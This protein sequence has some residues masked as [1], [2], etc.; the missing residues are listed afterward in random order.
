MADDGWTAVEAQFQNG[1]DREVR[2][3]KSAWAFF[4]AAEHQRMKEGDPDS[5]SAPLPDVHRLIAERWRNLSPADKNIYEEQAKADRD[6]FDAE[7]AAADAAALEAQARRRAEREN[8]TVSGSR[9]RTQAAAKEAPKLSIRK[10]R[11]LTT[12]Q[13]A[14]RQAVR[15]ARNARDAHIEKGK[16]ENKAFLQEQASQRLQYLL[17]QSDIFQHFGRGAERKSPPRAEKAKAEASEPMSPSR[18]RAAA[19][20]DD[21]ESSDNRDDT[22]LLRQPRNLQGQLRP[23]QL[24]GLNWLIR[25]QENGVNGILA[26]EMGLGKTLQSISILAYMLEYRKIRGPHLI[27][28]PKSTLSNWMNEFRKF[29]PS[30]RPVRFHGSKEERRDLAENVIKPGAPVS[31]LSWDVLVTTYEIANIE[32]NVIS[33]FAWQYLIIDEAHRLKNEASTFSRTVRGFSMRYRLLITGTPLQNNLH[34]LWALLNFLLP[35]VFASADQFDEWFD[36]DVDD[37]EAKERMIKQLHKLLR[38]FMLRRLK[39]DVEKTLPPKSE[40]I[41]FTGMSAVQKDLYK[42]ILRRDVDAILEANKTGKTQLMNIVMQLRKVCNHPYLFPGVENRSLDPLGEHLVTNCGKMVLLDKL[43]TALKARG[44]RVLIFTQMTRQLDILEDLMNMRAYSYCRID[45]NTNYEDREDQID[46]FNAAGSGIFAFILSTRAGGLG[47]NLQTAD[48]CILYDSDWNPQMDLQAQDRCHRIGQKRP[49]SVYRLVTEHSIEEK[50]VERAQQKLKLDAMV[51][52]QGRLQDGK[53]DKMSKEELLDAVR[54][55]ADKVFRSDDSTITDDDIDAILEAGRKRTED[56]NAKL[57][58]AEKGNLFDFRL[59]GNMKTQEFEGVDY[60][61]AERSRNA[62]MET[63]QGEKMVLGLGL[64]LHKRERKPVVTN[65]AEVMHVTRKSVKRI[66]KVLK[67]PKM[68]VYQF[69]NRERI[70]ELNEIAKRRYKELQQLGEISEKSSDGVLSLLEPELEAEKAQLLGSFFNWSREL[71]QAFV[72]ASGTFGRDNL[73]K[74]AASLGL[75]VEDV[76]KYK[77]TFWSRGPQDFDATEWERI[78]KKIEQGEKKLDKV[79]ALVTGTEQFVDQ[80]EN[81]WWEVPVAMMLRNRSRGRPLSDLQYNVFEDTL[82]LCLTRRYSYGNWDKVAEAIKRAPAVMSWVSMDYHLQ[83]MSVDDIARRCEILMQRAEKDM[84]SA[85]GDVENGS[86]KASFDKKM[87]D[88]DSEYKKKRGALVARQ[89]A[90]AEELAKL[91]SALQKVRDQAPGGVKELRMLANG[92]G[93]APISKGSKSGTKR[94]SEEAGGKK[95]EERESKARRKSGSAT[96]AEVKRE[97]I[98]LLLRIVSEAGST[99]VALITDA[100]RLRAEASARQ[101]MKMVSEI[102]EKKPADGRRG[103]FWRIRPEF[104]SL[105]NDTYPEGLGRELLAQARKM[106]REAEPKANGAAKAAKADKKQPSK[107]GQQKA[108]DPARN[109]KK[110]SKADGSASGKKRARSED[111]SEDGVR[112]PRPPRKAIQLFAQ[113]KKREL[114]STLQTD[115]IE[116]LAQAVR[117]AWNALA[118]SEKLL[119]IDRE[120]EDSLRYEAELKMQEAA[121]AK[122]KK[123]SSPPQLKDAGSPRALKPKP[124][125]AAAPPSPRMPHQMPFPMVHGR[126]DGFVHQG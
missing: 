68:P 48:T 43:L 50:I 49:V 25:L 62:E 98:P 2:P 106:V 87:E 60:S 8:L 37:E 56:M 44:H 93:I 121:R 79:N 108:K 67:L 59:D 107:D 116:V 19:Q 100:F 74:I 3:A 18:R 63:L 65:M 6:R 24:E 95:G 99:G 89:D 45:G 36:L 66:P 105:L 23:Y 119:W 75:E 125:A 109:A 39:V 21:S 57:K 112:D 102:A 118:D 82:L 64:G 40:T 14:K 16:E 124:P 69:Y 70:L 7:S 73:E 58:E 5:A 94:K 13:K 20:A 55:G 51:V 10:P 1:S 83:A 35:D 110:S 12:A 29:C 30:L 111:R 84:S 31:E 85:D 27:L 92:K 17:K 81:P 22:F 96:K 26:D 126:F 11:E 104:E 115:D 80:F 72:R 42:G 78:V 123:L 33:K 41:L 91:R 114:K 90:N 53:A 103:S 34:E 113:E 101:L 77:E 4:Q 71:Y 15:N 97:D 61:N 46:A 9:K 86:K 47:I 88:L 76:R 28:V 122:K 38:P 117:E 120:R 54:F 52:Q 32:K